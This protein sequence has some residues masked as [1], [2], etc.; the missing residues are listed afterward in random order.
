VKL[1]FDEIVEKI[2]GQTPSK[3]A[4]AREMATKI[5]MHI[6]GENVKEFL[7]KLD[8]YE[9][10]A[11]K[12][13]REKLLKSNKALMSYLLRPMDKI[14]T[15]KG[16]SIS[17]NVSKNEE[18]IIKNIEVS[19]VGNSGIKKHLKKSIK[20]KYV[21]DPNTILFFD[22]FIDDNG[23]AIPIEA[24]VDSFRQVDYSI[25]GNSIEWFIFKESTRIE[26]V[27]NK[28][29]KLYSDEN[30]KRYRYI[31]KDSDIIIDS[32]SGVFL[33]VGDDIERLGRSP[34][35]FLGD[36]LCANK[37]VFKSLIWDIVEEADE[38]L[39]DSSV[40]TVHKLAH[41]Y[42][43][44]WWYANDCIRCE[45]EGVIKS[46]VDGVYVENTCPSCGGDGRHKRK[47]ASDNIIL[48]VPKS[49]EP[50][51]APNVAGVVQP[52]TEWIEKMIHLEE[53]A[54]RKMYRSLWGDVK[55]SSGKRETATGRIIDA[56]PSV[57]RLRDHS[58]TF[59]K[60]HKH[61]IDT[62]GHIVLSK[63]VNSSVFY[64]TRY[65]LE[66]SDDISRL[67]IDSSIAKVPDSIIIDLVFRYYDSEYQNDDIELLKRKKLAYIEPFPTVSASDIIKTGNQDYIDKKLFFSEF[68]RSISDGDLIIKSIQELKEQFKIFINEN[69]QNGQN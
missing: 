56:Q 54:I 51:I 55:E 37:N 24:L 32:F 20:D 15:A 21:I 65:I 1:S 19:V 49:D 16:G 41:N 59:S 43:I 60:I 28:E 40:Q 62:I 6:T 44:Y 46:E 47:N 7:I 27:F 29:L 30:V 10:D 34:G 66:T 50:T 13:L 57:D 4:Y 38:F 68:S 17:Y 14:F 53:I 22:L 58:D 25:V 2:K 18:D 26:N 11:Q 8:D 12:E 39:R 3:I 52:N 61:Y 23:D 69:K 67:I 42:P 35:I 31:D 63:K 33:K 45:G 9:N 64:G 48:T 5:N 36:E